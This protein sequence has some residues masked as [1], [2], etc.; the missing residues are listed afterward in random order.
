[1]KTKPTL[2]Y[3]KQIFQLIGCLLLL[4]SLSFQSCTQSDEKYI[5][6]ADILDIR[7]DDDGEL[8][9]LLMIQHSGFTKQYHDIPT[10][11]YCI[12]MEDDI[13]VPYAQVPYTTSYDVGGG[14]HETD[15]TSYGDDRKLIIHL[16][17]KYEMP[18]F[19]D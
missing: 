8:H 19:V 11:S 1:M 7:R 18:F 15:F 4:I 17:L 12:Y 9:C 16:P 3:L 13:G 10:S 5:E 6:V 2:P 14:T